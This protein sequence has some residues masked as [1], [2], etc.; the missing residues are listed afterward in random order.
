MELTEILKE[1]KPTHSSEYSS[2]S[3][4]IPAVQWNCVYEENSAPAR[5]SEFAQLNSSTSSSMATYDLQF[6]SQLNT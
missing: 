5:A 4:D 2:G 6:P 1:T 3:P